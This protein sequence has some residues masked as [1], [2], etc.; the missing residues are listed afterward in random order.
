[1]LK[2][3]HVKSNETISFTMNDIQLS[4]M[5]L[6]L[7]VVFEALMDERSVTIAAEKLGKTPSAVSHA[8]GRLREQLGDPLMVKVGGKMQPSPF[9][10]RL[11]GD[12][13]PILSS[14][15]RAVSSPNL[16]D[17]SQSQRVFRV[18]LPTW[19]SLMARIYARLNAVAPR[20]VLEWSGSQRDGLTRL[21]DGT[22]DLLMMGQNSLAPE[23]VTRI[24]LPMM[25]LYTFARVDHPA[26][27]VWSQSE[28]AKWPHIM[29]D[30]ASPSSNSVD[31]GARATGIQRTIGARIP[32]FG[33]IAPIL[34][35]T[36]F[37]SNGFGISMVDSIDAYDLCILKPP[38]AP[39]Q[40]TAAVLWNTLLERDPEIDWLR[41]VLLECISDL[42]HETEI[43]F[44]RRDFIEPIER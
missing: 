33:A 32:D 3:I 35:R 11:I 21:V 7:L 4:Q 42:V 18:I 19:P 14:I 28:W 26:V 36:N 30:T 29:V 34:S 10:L 2:V 17:P 16:F 44:A 25:Q 23:G 20:V 40:G 9:A 15:Q 41:R 27:K 6:N 39:S 8:L 1:L 24:L 37:L 31:K 5:D 13:R 22:I 43:D 12:V 38:I